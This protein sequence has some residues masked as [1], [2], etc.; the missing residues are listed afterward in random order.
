MPQASAANLNK[1]PAE[2]K[3]NA[4][5][6]SG[7]KHV[8]AP[9]GPLASARSAGR[10]VPAQRAK[11]KTTAEKKQ[12]TGLKDYQLGDCLG[13]GACG[14]VYRALNWSNGETVAIKQIRLADL[15]KNEL[16]VIMLEIDLLKNLHHANIVKYHG[17][18]KSSESLY[19]ILE[20]CENGSL[21]SICRNFGKFPETLVALY[22][23]QVLQGLL[24]LHE[25]GV[26]HRDIKGANIL[27]T[28]EGTVKLAD[29]GV[30]TRNG[31]DLMNSSVVG[32]PYWMAPEVITLSGA[33]TA[34][35]IWSLGCTVIEL[36]EG[37]PP[38]H[39]FNSVAALYRI[40]NDDHPPLP[41]T[42]SQACEDF[43]MQCFQKDPNLRVTAKK[44]L[45]HPWIVN[46]KRANAVKP[47][48][49][50]QFDEVVKSVQEWN[51]ALKS[52]PNSSTIGST[53][54]S[55][56]IAPLPSDNTDIFIRN[57]SSSPTLNAVPP[58]AGRGPLDTQRLL[59]A[60]EEE[61]ECWD[62]DF[63]SSIG[64]DFLKLPQVK[65]ID[66]FDGKLSADKLKS[67]A[68]PSPVHTA[69]VSHKRNGSSTSNAVSD[70]LETV[71]AR[72]PRKI[73][74]AKTKPSND[75]ASRSTPKVPSL[76]KTQIRRSQAT[77]PNEDRQVNGPPRRVLKRTSSIFREQMAE[78]YSDLIGED[79][80]ED[81]FQEKLDQLRAKQERKTTPR[82]AFA[83]VQ[84]L[85]S[86]P[87]SA[88]STRSGRWSP[89][90]ESDHSLRRMKSSAEIMKYAD[91]VEDA[92]DFSDIFGGDD[93]TLVKTNKQSGSNSGAMSVNAMLSNLSS[94]SWRGDEEDEDDPFAE[95]EEELDD[96]MDMKTK[97]AREKQG[98]TVANVEH[99]V[100]QLKTN[101][102]DDVLADASQQLEEILF[103]NPETRRTVISSHGL[104]PILEILEEY[105]PRDISLALLKVINIIILDSVETQENFC[106][107]GGIPIVTRFADKKFPSDVRL[108]AAAFVQQMYRTSTLT[109]QMFI[110][111]GG[112]NVLVEFLE[113]DYDAER[114]LVLTG[115]NGVSRLFDLGGSTRNDFCR[116][117]SRSQVLYPL[118]LVLS[119]V[120]DEEGELA[121]LVEER[122]VGIFLCF[123]QAEN[124]VKDIVADRMV[125]K[126]VLKD[127]KRM[128]S[129][130][131]ITMLKF[132]KNLSMLSTT[133]DALQN[134]NAI[135]VL[136]DL[137]SSSMK[138]DNFDDISNNVLNIMFNLCRLS[139]TRQEDAALNGVIP[140]LQQLVRTQR[141]VKEFALPILCDMAHSGKVGR[142]LLWQNKGLPFYIT[143][144]AEPYW[145][146]T[147]LDAIFVW[148]QE[149]TAKVEENLLR[150][151][152]SNAIVQCFTS[153]ANSM[154]DGFENLL[155]PLQKLLRLSPPVAASLA[156]PDLF[157]RTAQKLSNKK[158]VVR[159]NLL[160]IIRSICESIDDGSGGTLIKRYSLYDAIHRLSTSDP[161]ILVRNMA[162]ELLNAAQSDSRSSMDGSSRYHPSRRTS[163]STATPPALLSSSS[164]PPT[165][166]SHQ[167]S[168]AQSTAYFDSQADP[169]GSNTSTRTRSNCSYRP[170]SRD[171][172]SLSSTDLGV[173]GYVVD[174]DA[175]SP[176]GEPLASKAR[177][178]P[179]QS[180]AGIGVGAVAGRSGRLSA[181]PQK[182]SLPP[183]RSE[184]ITNSPRAAGVQGASGLINPRRRRQTSGG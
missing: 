5:R 86:S 128:S 76:P 143:L 70:P 48:E 26:I 57:G 171:G 82:P 51:E 148:L 136:T 149:E 3:H 55:Q 131:L 54:P 133:L 58:N 119:R 45:K 156:H 121:E 151:G 122:I 68:S 61:T 66:N 154:G 102:P 180:L 160:R 47:V 60:N 29:F 124:H 129:S 93:K 9:N 179:R 164:Q 132:I 63:A 166:S 12:E 175:R 65:P 107:V 74:P 10:A 91:K 155:E 85:K 139:K 140:L 23:A 105:P 31:P 137:L 174:G 99:L 134:S 112:L 30:A 173:N 77:A 4:S 8:T 157:R 184:L 97:I 130:S 138:Q 71:R 145:Q 44:L 94:N 69:N 22:M 17:F 25:Q 165:P 144:L 79:E 80:E 41:E 123:S 169:Y 178:M 67:Y 84:D 20:Y 36:L 73:Q 182:E 118:S 167:R 87:S 177:L 27:T 46:N 21:H 92:N 146:V 176:F 158:A 98:R 142:K 35:D 18:V 120:L 135:E 39:K 40:V 56:A 96:A 42:M 62:D 64:S 7:E 43:L 50:A 88:A 13:K 116:I 152:F 108:E 115:V 141:P 100:A 72:S 90:S 126:R 110:S 15:P 75:K 1:T 147:A 113:E 111:C 38:Y 153:P 89:S 103:E 2:K 161:A 59:Q 14:S 183:L 181:S 114:D 127:L 16:R 159:G 172:L 19:I 24:Y 53:G 150:E 163:H 106:F 125:L 37:K 33:T 52:S 83:H 162:C 101:Q 78:D 109:L 32:T 117:L 34:S 28:K 11:E 104:L 168:T 81:A 6:S 49:T 95:L 170:A